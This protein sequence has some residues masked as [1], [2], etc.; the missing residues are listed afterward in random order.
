MQSVVVYP[1]VFR[2]ENNAGQLQLMQVSRGEC[3]QL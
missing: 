2:N 1:N 3:L